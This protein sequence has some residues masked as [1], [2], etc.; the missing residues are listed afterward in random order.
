MGFVGAFQVGQKGVESQC[1]KP[2]SMV[3]GQSLWDKA[4]HNNT[5]YFTLD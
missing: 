5:D 3:Y 4:S 2:L 1:L